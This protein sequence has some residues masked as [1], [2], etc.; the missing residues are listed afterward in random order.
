MRGRVVDAA[1]GAGLERVL[2]MVED[3]G[4]TTLTDATGAFSLA[5]VAPGRRKLYV[6][7]V[8]YALARREIDVPAAGLEL[9]IPL[10][11]GTGTYTENVT[12]ASER[13]AAAEP[14]VAVQQVLGSADLQNLRGVLADDPMRAVQVLPG[15]TSTDDLRSEFT[16]RASAF[17]NVNMTVDGF[18]TPHVL[19]T[20][21]AVE[22][23]SGSG[24]VAMINSDVLQDVALLSGGYPQR[25]GNRTGAEVDF[26]LREGSR[27]R[28]QSRVAISGT[29][30]SAVFE[31]P[32]GGAK[33]GSWLVSARQSYLD[34]LIRQLDVGDFQFGFTDAQGKLIYD[35]TPSN[36]VE[37]TLLGGRSR[38]EEH[39]GDLD[40][41]DTF[42]GRN[43][44]AIAIAGWRLMTPRAVVHLRALAASNTFDNTDSGDVRIDDGSDR[45]AAVRLDAS[46]PLSTHLTFE[47][48]ATTEWTAES[49]S[50]QR[51]TGGRYRPI[52]EFTGDAVRTGGYL[53]ARI[54]AGPLTVVPGA[55]ADQWSLTGD[56]TLSPWL[57]AQATLPASFAIRAG[58]GIYHQ[59]PA[60]EQ[61]IGDLAAPTSRPM[62]AV[63]YD[64]AVEHRIGSSLRWQVAVYDREEEDFFRR[65]L[66]EHRLVGDDFIRGQRGA[67]FVQ[68][69]NA[70]ARGVEVLIQRKSAGGLSGWFSYAYGRNRVTDT[71][72]GETYWGDNDQRHTLN[73]YGFYRISD[74]LSVSAK[75]RLG[76][77][78]P[79][80]GYYRQEGEA[81][82]LSQQRN[83]LRLPRYSRVD[84]RANRTFNWS[85][86]RL[87]LF[88]EVMNVFNR[89]N[90]R[91]TPPAVST[92]SRG[93][94]SLFEQMVPVVPSVGVLF[95]F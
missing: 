56:T 40:T 93:V 18:A 88:A 92:A 9:T 75:A 33:R 37:L 2:V 73:V 32:L 49:R 90:V 69:L 61:V 60:M 53:Q 35:V 48:G 45:V 62:R 17:A 8:G 47:G 64:L 15:V 65:P 87:T 7:M 80:P 42:V 44:S 25:F 38:G 21:R 83:E 34:L 63:H 72:S 77:N 78:V 94:S 20:V 71:M 51:F 66:S 31:G 30:A 6:S 22:D 46:F 1:T 29:N 13:F 14:A 5:G 57:Q 74:R 95:E 43:A 86:G 3:G 12:V 81:Y 89:D 41:E 84:I 67:P 58:T 28:T 55:R 19:H 24:S 52:N 4:P 79:A 10:T 85:S 70:F 27:D 76:S 82:Y 68:S 11:E 54:D 16:V 59:F 26:R 39:S 50:R 91:F 36:R 23:Y